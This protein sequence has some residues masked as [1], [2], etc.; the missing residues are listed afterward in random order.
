MR[1]GKAKNWNRP[2]REEPD[3]TGTNGGAPSWKGKRVHGA[4]MTKMKK[5]EGKRGKKGE[6]NNFAGYLFTNVW[7]KICC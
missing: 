3:G 6:N 5:M 1:K 4:R 7:E 2:I